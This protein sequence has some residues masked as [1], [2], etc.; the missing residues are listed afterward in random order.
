MVSDGRLIYHGNHFVMYINVESQCCTPESNT[1]LYINY[2]SK[3]AEKFFNILIFFK[4][5]DP[6]G[7]ETHAPCSSQ[8]LEKTSP[9]RV[10]S[11][12]AMKNGPP[13]ALQ[14][15]E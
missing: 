15:G 6:A 3:K 8:Q 10:R 11:W 1:I 4:K 14:H 9:G 12:P 13:T 7:S 5:V 2:I